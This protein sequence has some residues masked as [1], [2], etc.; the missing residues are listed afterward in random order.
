MV[1]IAE[2][3][4]AGAIANPMLPLREG[5]RHLFSRQP[6]EKGRSVRSRRQGYRWLC[7]LLVFVTAALPGASLHAV[8]AAAVAATR[9]VPPEPGIHARMS[10]QWQLSG[11][12]ETSYRADVYDIDLF[13]APP[14]IVQRLHAAHRR[15][16]CYLSAGSY[17]DWRSDAGAFLRHRAVLG[18]PYPGWPGERWLDIRNISVL[19]P[20]MRSRLD[21]CKRKG[22][23]G[24]E[25]D[26]VDGYTADGG[27]GFPLSAT[28][29]LRYNRWL[30]AQ[31]H[32]RGLSVG[33][34]N[35]G[36]QAAVLQPAFDWALTEDCFQQGWC[37]QEEPFLRAR[38]AVFSA[39]YTDV[40]SGSAVEGYCVRAAAMG[41]S[42]IYKQRDLGAWARTCGT[43]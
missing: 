42:L 20:I 12:I 41:I 5:L 2:E 18:R 33:L 31:A 19:G 35:D 27:T 13:D 7:F 28:D 1:A 22:F 15:A 6:I 30:A 11:V 23:D 24:V 17:E 14:A 9:W 36:E 34:K 29:Q 4:T 25:A 8:A 26:N 40:T 10:F 16:V 3:A 38:K 39:E 32:A 37:D 43:R 21:L